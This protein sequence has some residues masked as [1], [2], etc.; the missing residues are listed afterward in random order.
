MA[1]APTLKELRSMSDVVKKANLVCTQHGTRACR[2]SSVVKREAKVV[3][4]GR[5]KNQ[6]GQHGSR[7][8][9]T[10]TMV[11]LWRTSRN[12]SREVPTRPNKASEWKKD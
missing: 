10:T 2:W 9:A 12:Q 4:F 3:F 11:D 1:Q 5:S 8:G 6:T 7:R